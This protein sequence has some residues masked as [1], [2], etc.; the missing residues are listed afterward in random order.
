MTT[1]TLLFEAENLLLDAGRRSKT[2]GY[3]DE[4]QNDIKVITKAMIRVI[5]KVEREY[6]ATNEK[7]I[8]SSEISTQQKS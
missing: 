2:F 8:Q 6:N 4:V 5:S 1:I 3:S 7:E